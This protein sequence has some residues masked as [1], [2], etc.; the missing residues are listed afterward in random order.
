[1]ARAPS[2]RRKVMPRP[3]K[4]VDC[5]PAT[6]EGGKDHGVSVRIWRPG[7]ERQ[8]RPSQTDALERQCK[9]LSRPAVTLKLAGKTALLQQIYESIRKKR[10]VF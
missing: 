1:M 2:F 3:G 10:I 8:A 9:S 7:R 6:E 5:P 4:A